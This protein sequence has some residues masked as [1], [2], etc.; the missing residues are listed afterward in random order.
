MK[1]TTK[2]LFNKVACLALA[3]MMVLSVFCVSTPTEVSAAGLS[4]NSKGKSSVTITDEQ[5]TTATGQ[6]TWIKFTA[7]QDGYLKVTAKMASTKYTDFVQGYWTLYDKT[8]K[9][10][11]SPQSVYSTN[12]NDA[13]AYTTVFGVKKGVTYYLNVLSDGGVKLTASF[14]KVTDKSGTKKAKALSIKQKKDATGL[15]RV[16]D[17]NSDWYKFTLTKKQYL[18]I[19]ITPYATDSI[20]VNIVGP[21]KLKGN[22]IIT[23]SWYG[24]KYSFEIVNQYD[25]PVKA[26]TGTYYVQIKATKKTTNGYYKINWK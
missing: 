21:N 14:T 7:K 26:S 8:K 9:K 4:F 5:D 6:P 1:N 12:Y 17:K 3:A 24:K 2:K 23:K 22:G 13:S 15:I 20:T 25:Q 11:V 10:A 19:N 18:S 16:G